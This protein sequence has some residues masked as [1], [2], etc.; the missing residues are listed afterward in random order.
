MEL[1]YEFCH[2]GELNNCISAS[3][4]SSLDLSPWWMTTSASPEAETC[5][6]INIPNIGNSFCV[7]GGPPV[8]KFLIKWDCWFGNLSMERWQASAVAIKKGT[9]REKQLMFPSEW[10]LKID[11]GVNNALTAHLVVEKYSSVGTKWI[12]TNI[13]I[14]SLFGLITAMLISISGNSKLGVE[15]L[16]QPVGPLESWLSAGHFLGDLGKGFRPN[17]LPV[18]GQECFFQAV[19]QFWKRWN[20]FK[21]QHLHTSLMALIYSHRCGWRSDLWFELKRSHWHTG[22]PKLTWSAPVFPPHCLGYIPERGNNTY[23]W[24]WKSTFGTQSDINGNWKKLHNV[25]SM[26][27]P[28]LQAGGWISMRQRRDRNLSFFS[29]AFKLSYF[30]KKK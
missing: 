23:T 28:T 5:G 3:D 21:S 10:M 26:S 12:F 25:V 11:V 27:S 30:S 18:N 20:A 7:S 4:D 15:V 17:I 24:W 8:G 29:R 6:P 13:L 9:G 1:F 14:S 22:T 2:G 19:L 16:P